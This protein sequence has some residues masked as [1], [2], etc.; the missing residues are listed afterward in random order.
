MPESKR[1]KRFIDANSLE[2]Y[3]VE[4]NGSRYVPW[5]A[6]AE[7]PEELPET[8]GRWIR[9]YSGADKRRSCSRCGF[10]VR[11]KWREYQFCPRCGVRME[12]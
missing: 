8:G 1:R 5:L 2:R 10:S 3:T 6:V 11:E 9:K 12:G 7:V 4:I